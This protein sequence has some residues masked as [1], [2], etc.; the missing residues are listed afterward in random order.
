[1]YIKTVEKTYKNTGKI[2][3]EYRFIRGYRTSAGPRQ[4][5]LLTV[6]DIPLPKDQW[7]TLADTMDDLLKG[8]LSLFADEAVIALAE[9]Y[10]DLIRAR[11]PELSESVSGNGKAPESMGMLN[12][13]S[14]RLSNDRSIG[15]EHIGYSMYKRLG[16]EEY[17][18]GTDLS[19]YERQ[20]AALS[21]IGRLVEPRSE[22]ATRRWSHQIS[23]IGELLGEDC[24]DLGNNSLYRISDLIYTHKD[25]IESFLRERERS[26]F[27]LEE[28]ICLYDLTNTFVEGMA[29]KIPKAKF[30]RS[31]EKRSDCRLLT[32][33]MVIDEQGFCKRSTIL[34]GSVSE[35]RT[36]KEMISS[37][38]RESF[39]DKTPTIIMDAGIA[40]KENLQYLRENDYHYLCVS[41]NKPMSTEMVDKDKMVTVHSDKTNQVKAQLFRGDGESILFCH[42]EKM[43]MKE[44]GMQERY[45]RNFEDD[46]E[47]IRASL[48]KKYSNKSYGTIM[49]RVGR[50]RERYPSINRYFHID[51]QQHDDVVVSIEYHKI[52][53]EDAEERFSGNYWLR[54][55]LT[56]W[57]ELQL[58]NTYIMLNR[59]EA[60]FRSLKHELAFRPI[61]HRVGR[62]VDAHIFIAVLAYH[63]L[64]A[65]GHVLRQNG[66]HDSW[67][68]VRE[69]MSTH[70]VLSVTSK[71]N[72]S[73]Y[74]ERVVTSPEPYHI[75]IYSALGITLMPVIKPVKSSRKK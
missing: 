20:L 12:R 21:I 43:E 48:T 15:P 3:L 59:I 16:F 36:L 61:F 52:K 6:R 54:T 10:C 23:G 44:R 5:T 25:K 57:N 71:N 18:K 72:N 66:I 75:S 29:T 70:R 7:K 31:K 2:Y 11:H 49:Q 27:N 22:H 47:K 9:H 46:L 74:T 33:G 28:S 65:I 14:L 45:Y 13:D 63:L 4:K 37:L 56:T 60:A 53:H 69:L 42:S 24:S 38:S 51:V 40:T 64:N 32:L 62:R 19:P 34:E 50:L 68:T 35:P 55:S 67:K 1:M 58:W 26:I 8:R 17:F 73:E 30:G 41:R 39:G